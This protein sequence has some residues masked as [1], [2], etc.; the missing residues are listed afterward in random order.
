[1]SKTHVRHDLSCTPI[2]PRAFFA[3]LAKCLEKDVSCKPQKIVSRPF[4]ALNSNFR[5]NYL[6]KEVLR[7]YPDFDLG[8]DTSAVALAGFISDEAINA[9]TNE[10]LSR[11]DM[12]NPYVRQV[13]SLACRK[14]V[15][16]LGKFRPDR[17]SVV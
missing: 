10:R 16:V 14:A 12:E 5:D 2:E 15:T 17:K 4:P 7:K 1:M 6:L 3:L 8:I 11:C 9:E 13:F